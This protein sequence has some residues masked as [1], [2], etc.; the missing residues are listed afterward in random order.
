MNKTYLTLYLVSINILISLIVIHITLLLTIA[1]YLN[2]VDMWIL[3]REERRRLDIAGE[4]GPRRME[5]RGRKGIL[6]LR[7]HWKRSGVNTY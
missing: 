3:Y 4:G 5:E 2:P 1:S 7:W 6:R